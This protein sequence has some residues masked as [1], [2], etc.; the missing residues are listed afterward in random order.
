MAV[1]VVK[2]KTQFETVEET[3]PVL[4]PQTAENLV[5]SDAYLEALIFSC[6]TTK[7]TVTVKDKQGTPT[8]VFKFEV[9]PGDPTVVS[10]PDRYCPGGITWE[11][12]AGDLVVGYARWKR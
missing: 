2:A 6:A 10:F 5:A 4:V 1:T 3:V 7:D 12:T 11:S 8:I 9:L